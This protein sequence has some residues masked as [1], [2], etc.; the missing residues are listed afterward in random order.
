MF[1]YELTDKKLIVRLEGEI[2]HHSVYSA[3]ERIDELLFELRP[4]VLMFDLSG[5]S[6][7]DSSGLGLILGRYRK[8]TQLGIEVVLSSLNPHTKKL[9]ATAG[10]E[11]FIKIIN[12]G[13]TQDAV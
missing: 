12:D 5:T 8:C 1:S 10:I 3:R 13:H 11:K 7:M 9:V 4:Q 6:F 2:D